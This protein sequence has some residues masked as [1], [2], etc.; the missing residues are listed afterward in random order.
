M[1]STEYVIETYETISGDA[2]TKTTNF[3]K[4][5]KP[6]LNRNA[7]PE[8][9]LK[10][11]NFESSKKRRHNKPKELLQAGLLLNY[12]NNAWVNNV[13]KAT[14]TAVH[15]SEVSNQTTL[16]LEKHDSLGGY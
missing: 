14:C 12:S 10:L 8:V 2:Q 15:S 1:N 9:I 3:L 16:L 13:S 4:N 11:F 5:P 6:I 7:K